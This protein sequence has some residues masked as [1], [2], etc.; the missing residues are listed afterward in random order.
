MKTPAPALRT[1]L[2]AAALAA[3]L[4][5][6]ALSTY[7]TTYTFNGTTN[8]DWATTTNWSTGIAAPTNGTFGHR[9]DINGAL[10]YSAAQGN[11][12]YTSTA[13]SFVISN[14]GSL[15]ITGGH[16]TSNNTN[17]S[18]DILGNSTASTS[19]TVNG[20]NYTSNALFFNNSNSAA[21]IALNIQS[22]TAT[23][24]TLTVQGPATST[25]TV[26]LDGGTL[27][28]TTLTASGLGSKTLNFNGG[29]LKARSSALN[30]QGFTNTFV[31]SG[32][33]VID[34]N[35]FNPTVT[36]ALLTDTV[37]TGGGL[38]KSGTGTLTLSGANTYTGATTI[39]TGTLAIAS[40]GS[41]A[42]TAYTIA[43]GAAFNAS[44]KSSYSLASVATTIHVGATTSGFFNGPS[45]ALTFGNTLTL[46][47]STASLADGQTYNLFDF[48]SQ[49]GDFSSIA[50]TG[51]ITGSLLLTSTDTWT[52]SL[53]GYEFT[54]SETSGVLSVAAIPEPSTY[55]M[56]A[57][58]GALVLTAG[59]RRRRSAA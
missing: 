11:T 53:S 48:G 37:S 42:S 44:A 18:A 26:N 4:S 35:G 19:L 54:F 32:G 57:G 23:I 51:S 40:T 46:N 38:T 27:A 52:G 21:T 43:D 41:L 47:F 49:T 13:R 55:A 2:K 45:G 9:V 14:G 59:N 31:K 50:L 58:L 30:V 7:A 56:A 29:V 12:T 22:G 24:N 20:G 34:T 28:V 5:I 10:I 17:S 3:S 8:S 1:S 33:A 36:Q 39:N 15:T 16:F 25:S 6:S